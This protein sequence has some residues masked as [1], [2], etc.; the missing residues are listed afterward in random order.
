MLEPR[1]GFLQG[2][3]F[4]VFIISFANFPAP[5]DSLP[6]FWYITYDLKF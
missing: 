6:E 2:T 1:S 3:L 5:L 4:I